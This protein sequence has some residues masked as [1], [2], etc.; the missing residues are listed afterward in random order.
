MKSLVRRLSQTTSRTLPDDAVQIL[1][2]AAIEATH[3]KYRYF[4][5]ERASIITAAQMKVRAMYPHLFNTEV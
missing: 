5:P 3:C 1:R 2:N 4:D